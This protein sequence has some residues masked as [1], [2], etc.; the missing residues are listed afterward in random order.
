MLF[1]GPSGLPVLICDCLPVNVIRA[2]REGP[3]NGLVLRT[4]S[5]CVDWFIGVENTDDGVRP[6]ESWLFAVVRVTFTP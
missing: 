2:K 5:C 6:S 3:G 1:T 4:R